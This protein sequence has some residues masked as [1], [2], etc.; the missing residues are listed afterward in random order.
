MKRRLVILLLLFS[1][2]ST[3]FA[4]ITIDDCYQKARINYPLVKQYDLIDQTKE[5]NLSNANK[6]YLPQILFSAKASY[7]SDVTRIPINI[8]GVEGLSKDQYGLTLEL[9]QTLWDGGEIKSKKEGIRADSEVESQNLEVNIYAIRNRINQLYFGILLLDAQIE[10]NDIYQNDLEKSYAKVKAY[11]QNGVAHQA[12]LDAVKVEQLKVR[13]ARIQLLHARSAYLDML[14][15]FIGEKLNSGATLVKPALNSWVDVS[16]N[17]PELALYDAQV[18][19]YE[20]RKKEINARLMPRVGLFANGGYGKPSLNMLSNDLLVYGVGGI[21]VSWNISNFYATKNNKRLIE[22]GINT[23]QVQKETF[24]F[25]TQ[26]DISQKENNIA[27]Y[28]DQLKYDDEIIALRNSIKRSSEIKMANGMISG[29]DLI[30]DI[31][32]ENTAVL[33]KIVH[34]IE[35]YLAIYNLKFTTNH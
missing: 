23:V 18:R 13:Q 25:N 5:Y 9:S 22:A 12:D 35:M 11:V 14:S 10:Q 19:N 21:R 26:M 29:I 3:G 7:Q 27:S 16:I 2:S 6:G 1:G 24:L 4:Q 17:R 34:E 31:N 30:R 15:A 32:A 8:P 28:R 33:D 20:I